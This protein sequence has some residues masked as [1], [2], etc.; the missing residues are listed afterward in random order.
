[1]GSSFQ[2]CVCLVSLPIEPLVR[3]ER[4]E[5]VATVIIDRPERRNALGS[6]AAKAVADAINEASR[7]GA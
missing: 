5:D 7:T 6:A 1:M 3:I 4:D 2:A